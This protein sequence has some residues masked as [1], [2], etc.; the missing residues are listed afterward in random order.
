MIALRDMRPEDRD[1]VRQWRN[2]PAV[3]RYMY[4]DGE[5][6]E[7]EHA[8][9]FARVLDDPSCTYWI[10]TCD[11]ADVG[12]ACITGIDR[13]HSRCSWAFYIASS[14]LRGR[15][16]GSVVEY[17]VLSHVFDTLGLEK[18]CCEVLDLNAPVIEMHKRFGFSEEGRL[19]RHI[20]K[21]ES[22]H[23]VIMLAMLREDWLAARSAIE[24]RLAAKGLLPGQ[25][26]QTA[27]V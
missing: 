23:D 1:R 10:I 19:R 5:I 7:A 18:L 4:T 12:L 6:A 16:V 8:A 20:R 2:L 24:E 27:A 26:P 3:A 25:A 14:D 11:G 22:W 9:W 21:G 13:V 15:G 17:S